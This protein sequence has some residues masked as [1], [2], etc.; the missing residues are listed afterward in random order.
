MRQIALYISLILGLVA[1]GREDDTAH[2]D[3]QSITSLWR[4]A[5]RGTV[6][7]TDDIYLCGVVVANDRFGEL[8]RAVV[9]EDESGG[10]VVEVD[11]DDTQHHF[12]LYSRVVI[13][14]AGLRL[15]SIGPKLLLGAEPMG[16]YPV[17]RIPAT[18]VG[19]HICVLEENNN[20]PTHR[21]RRVAELGYCD[22][23]RSIS[24]ANLCIVDEE[25]Y[26]MWADQDTLTG[27]C[28][29]SLRHFCQEGDTLRVVVD[30]NC[31]YALE[32]IPATIIGLSGILDWYGDD[33]AL[34][35]VNHS[36][37]RN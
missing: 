35:I 29:T 33:M 10:V 15:G 32:D 5:G 2:Y 27:R 8:A 1:C 4:Y 36:I 7:I 26:S 9:V 16:D 31:S 11:M 21:Q 22:V 17:D 3:Y 14:C 20:T 37:Y 34:R 18:K 23:L 24:V 25:R 19:N 13:R 6:L 28:C 30:A 12:P